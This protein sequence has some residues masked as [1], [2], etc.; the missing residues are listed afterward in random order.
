MRT[1][2]LVHALALSFATCLATALP[3]GA[4]ETPDTPRVADA[5]VDQAFEAWRASPAERRVGLDACLNFVLPYRGSE[6]PL[7]DWLA[8]LRERHADLPG[9]ATADVRS[10][11]KWVNRDT[12]ERI[13]LNE[14]VFTLE[15][16]GQRWW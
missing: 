1:V 3:A 13:K 8:P 15:S 2:A 4:E 5:H 9:E 11:Y 14:R 16:G 12:G 7:D 6:E 10:L